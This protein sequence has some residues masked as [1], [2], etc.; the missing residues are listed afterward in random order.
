MMRAISWAAAGCCLLAAVA[1]RTATAATCT[2]DNVCAQAS[3]P[4]VLG[5]QHYWLLY[6]DWSTQD[7]GGLYDPNGE[8]PYLNSYLSGAPGARW[9]GTAAQADYSGNYYSGSG[10]A[11]NPVAGLAGTIVLPVAGSLLPYP[12]SDDFGGYV[13]SAYDESLHAA[14]A[15]PADVFILVLPSYVG[16]V[17]FDGTNVS[18]AGYTD[19][20]YPLQWVA[21]GYF[22]GADYAAQYTGCSTMNCAVSSA[23]GSAIQNAMTDPRVGDITYA[24]YSDGVAPSGMDPYHPYISNKCQNL[25]GFDPIPTQ[26]ALKSSTPYRFDATAAWSN[27]ANDN[28]GA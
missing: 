18:V 12:V 11:E 10:P 28:N 17:K 27:S 26:V 4:F 15:T 22:T 20:E 23:L 9:W 13:T 24:G 14:G 2:G 19:E 5:G 3:S 8:I 16:H 21:M 7:G 25:S 1:P 6:L